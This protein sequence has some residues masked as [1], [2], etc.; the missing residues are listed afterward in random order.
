[1]RCLVIGAGIVGTTTAFELAADGHEVEVVDPAPGIAQRASFANGGVIG[2]SQVEPWAAPGMPLSIL[3]WLGRDDAP[4]LLRPRELPRLWRWGWRFLR[5]CNAA[6]YRASTVAS[7]GLALHSLDR[8]EAIRAL[9]GADYA[10][11]TGTVLKVFLDPSAFAKARA[12]VEDLAADGL[13]ARVVDLE[14]ARALEPAL[15][16]A[17]ERLAGAVAYTRDVTGDCNRFAGLL[18]D[19]LAAKGVRFRLGAAV[20]GFRREGARIGAVAIDGEE[21]RYDV[22]VAA[23]G[24]WTPA[25]VREL[26]LRPLIAPT[27]GITITVPAR[28]WA[29]APSA[30]VIDTARIFGLVRLGHSLRVSGS[31]ELTG[32]DDRPEERRWKALTAKVVEIFPPFAACLADGPPRVWAGLRPTTPDGRPI[33]GATPVENLYLNAGH[34][35]QGWTGACGSARVVADLIAGRTPAVDPTS[36]A[37]A[38]FH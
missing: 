29:R 36:F 35:P 28:A 11:S 9:L 1:V 24:S 17:S 26:G 12:Q 20:T 37:Y 22:V 16:D 2:A 6:D 38:R 14:E 33:L 5:A 30:A 25:L 34:G 7:L 31:A 27:K 19:R 3:R 13:P 23:A 4:L 15:Q 18:A 21:R 8:L 32:F 10:M